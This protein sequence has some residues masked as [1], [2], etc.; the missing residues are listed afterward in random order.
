MLAKQGKASSYTAFAAQ[1]AIWPLDGYTQQAGLRWVTTGERGRCFG[2][3][4]TV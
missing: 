3:P 1:L 4:T 2:L